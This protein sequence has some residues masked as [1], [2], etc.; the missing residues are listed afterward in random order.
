MGLFLLHRPG[1]IAVQGIVTGV[2]GQRLDISGDV[3]LPVSRKT[4]KRSAQ[5]Y[6]NRTPN[7][8]KGSTVIALTKDNFAVEALFTGAETPDK[9]Y[10]LEAFTVRYSGIFDFEKTEAAGEQHLFSGQVIESVQK[11]ELTY[12]KIHVRSANKNLERIVVEP[13]DI[14]RKKGD[15]VTVI[16][17][18]PYVSQNGTEIYPTKRGQID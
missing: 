1:I 11:N 14:I 12:T 15:T 7:F 18:P 8:E 10:I 16:T 17:G 6:M 4:E 13:G 3:Y 9:S 2:F 5:I